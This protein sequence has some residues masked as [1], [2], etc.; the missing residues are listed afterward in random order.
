MT[1]RKLTEIQIAEEQKLKRKILYEK[2]FESLDNSDGARD[3]LFF[4][5]P[6]YVMDA[7]NKWKKP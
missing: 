3:W 4:F 7:L 6:N 2:Q 1:D 5:A